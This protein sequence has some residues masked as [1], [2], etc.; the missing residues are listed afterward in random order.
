MLLATLFEALIHYA[1]S[2]GLQILAYYMHTNY[3]KTVTV[4]LKIKL[5]VYNYSL[6]SMQ[7]KV[8]ELNEL[9]F[10]GTKVIISVFMQLLLPQNLVK[11]P[12]LVYIVQWLVLLFT[13]LQPLSTS[14]TN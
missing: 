2:K 3:N 13:T 7:S 14:S 8:N 9:R 1:I 4:G 11:G 12:P 10:L 6:Y 5:K